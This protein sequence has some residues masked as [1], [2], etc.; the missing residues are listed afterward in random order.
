MRR[1]TLL[2]GAVS[3][4]AALAM[5]PAIKAQA[6]KKLSFLTWNISDQEQLFKEEFADFQKSYPGTEIEWLDRKGTELPAFY[7]NAVGGRDAA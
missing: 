6:A 7:Q 1:R 2:K 3:G 4:M 5:P